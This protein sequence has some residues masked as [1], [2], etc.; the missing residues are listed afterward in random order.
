[1]LGFIEIFPTG[2]H[3]NL[4][5]HYAYID[6]CSSADIFQFLDKNNILLDMFHIV[7]VYSFCNV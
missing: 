4:I 1:M 7:T 2:F 3:T 5:V 6:C